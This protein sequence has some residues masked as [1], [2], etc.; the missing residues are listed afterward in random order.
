MDIINQ[1]ITTVDVGIVAHG[2]NCQRVMGS[3]VALAIRNRWPEVYEAYMNDPYG[4]G[5]QLIGRAQ[6]VKVDDLLYVANCY[7]QVNFG[8]DGAQYASLDAIRFSLTDVMRVATDKHLP[9]YLPRIGCGLGGLKWDNVRAV[10]E[11]L[12]EEFP[13]VAVTVCD[14]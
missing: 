12:E 3:G 2:V 14:I 4:R 7:T 9:L 8:R 6:I 5:V 11:G 1:D 13:L 10:I